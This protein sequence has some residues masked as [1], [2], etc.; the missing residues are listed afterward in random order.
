MIRIIRMT[1][2]SFR[3]CLERG[4]GLRQQGKDQF[5]FQTKHRQTVARH[6]LTTAVVTDGQRLLSSSSLLN[7]HQEPQSLDPTQ[8][9]YHLSKVSIFTLLLIFNSRI[10]GST[11]QRGLLSETVASCAFVGSV[12]VVMPVIQFR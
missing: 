11:S 4:F 9:N 10:R 3:P 5:L 12:R 8:I 7:P 6:I 1:R 2:Y